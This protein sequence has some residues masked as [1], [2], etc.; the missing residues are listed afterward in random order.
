MSGD[1]ARRLQEAEGRNGQLTADNDSLRRRIGDITNEFNIKITNYEQRITIYE[2]KVGSY[3]QRLSGNNKDTDD[4]RREVNDLR[5]K[6]QELSNAA[7]RLHEYEDKV[8][9]LSS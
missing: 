6:N 1:L 4:L 3:E 5:R 9:M 7:G 2:Q 8:V